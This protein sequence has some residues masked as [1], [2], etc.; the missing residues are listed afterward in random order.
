L[1]RVGD[2]EVVLPDAFEHLPIFRQL[3]G[4]IGLG[5]ACLGRVDL[6][7]QKDGQVR[8]DALGI[9]LPQPLE[10]AADADEQRVEVTFNPHQLSADNLRDTIS[11]LGYTVEVV[12]PTEY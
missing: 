7:V 9:D 6:D 11:D 1:Q 2:L 12:E 4:Q 10:V 8:T 5:A 3:L